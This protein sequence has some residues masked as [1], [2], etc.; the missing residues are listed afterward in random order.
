MQATPK[1]LHLGDMPVAFDPAT[2]TLRVGNADVPLVEWLEFRRRVDLL[3]KRNFSTEEWRQLTEQMAWLGKRDRLP[4]ALREYEQ[5]RIT[6]LRGW[7]GLKLRIK[8]RLA[9]IR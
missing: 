3:M 4:M 1:D 6:P 2:K 9:G 5:P 7:S 8:M